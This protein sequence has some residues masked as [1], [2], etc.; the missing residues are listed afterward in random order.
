MLHSDEHGSCWRIFA[1][2]RSRGGSSRCPFFEHFL[3]MC[4]HLPSPTIAFVGATCAFR[5]SRQAQRFCSLRGN[6]FISNGRGDRWF[7][8][9]SE[10]RKIQSTG[11][12]PFAKSSAVGTE[13][14]PIALWGRDALAVFRSTNQSSITLKAKCRCSCRRVL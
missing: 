12:F 10:C 3:C 6:W 11:R 14:Q 1:R 9:G 5:C 13:W 2:Q 7:W 8:S 4:V